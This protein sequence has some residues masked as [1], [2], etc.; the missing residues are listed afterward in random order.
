MT[1][2]EIHM[3]AFFALEM[4]GLVG[5]TVVL[6]T[7]LLPSRVSRHPIWINFHITWMISCA[8]YLLLIGKPIHFVPT[9]SLCFAQAVLI[10]T[11][12][13]LTATATI[14]LVINVMITLRSVL[15]SS[16]DIS[17]PKAVAALLVTMPYV[18][19]GA[20]AAIAIVTGLRDPAGVGRQE[21][22]FYCNMKNSL[23]GKVS[24]VSVAVI[25]L[26]GLILEVIV[27]I[28]LRKNWTNLGSNPSSKSMSVRVIA[29]SLVGLL[30]IIVSMVFFFK[31]NHGSG[32]NLI[33]S[34]VPVAAALI[35][36]TQRDIIQSWVAG[37]FWM[38]GRPSP[39]E[40]RHTLSISRR[41]QRTSLHRSD[42]ERSRNHAPEYHS[43][44][45]WNMKD[46]SDTDIH[47]QFGYAR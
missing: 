22:G 43:S 14:V 2:D 5:I 36:G 39:M 6:L 9:H 23:P 15:R 41:S 47:I 40:S 24:S 29:F 35:F 17:H 4:A 8:S 18:A 10:Y 46:Q 7:A 21:A 31:R 38:V 19:G 1:E 27:C 34:I 33:L 45:F 42:I 20:L 44:E 11:V 30:S 26:L 3:L 12:P 28:D 25:M 16:A 37:L 13:I 32:L